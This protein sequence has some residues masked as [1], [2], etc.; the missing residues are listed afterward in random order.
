MG[1]GCNCT[2]LAGTTLRLKLPLPELRIFACLLVLLLL[3]PLSGFGQD[4]QEEAAN[5]FQ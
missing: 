2:S 4:W 5:S 1:T 3:L